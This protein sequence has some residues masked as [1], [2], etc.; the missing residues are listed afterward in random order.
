MMMME[1]PKANVAHYYQSSLLLILWA[2][3][4]PPPLLAVQHWM[5]VQQMLWTRNS[6]GIDAQGR[7]V[8]A[9]ARQQLVQRPVARVLLWLLPL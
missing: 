8:A 9:A 1:E 4:G 5:Q 3:L 6:L 7:G 2:G